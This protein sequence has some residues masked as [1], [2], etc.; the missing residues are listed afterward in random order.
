[1]MNLF[2]GDCFNLE[3]PTMG[4]K[5][6][7][8]NI[9]ERCG[10]KLQQNSFTKHA[11]ILDAEDFRVAFGDLSS[12]KDK[13][14]RLTRDD[15]LK[16]GDVF[17]VSRHNLYE[18]YGIYIGNGMVINYRG[19]YDIGSKNT[20]R[21]ER[22]KD[23]VGND[24]LFVLHFYE[25]GSVPR[26]ISTKTEFNGADRSTKYVPQ[27]FRYYSKIYSPQETI[28]RAMSK[29]GE[30]DYNLLFHNCEH[31]AMWCKTGKSICL[32]E[33]AIPNKISLVTLHNNLTPLATQ[34]VWK[35]ALQLNQNR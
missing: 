9:E 4:G 25:D 20:V 26:K 31:F 17:G 6:C 18:H 15:F 10:Y 22:L 34:P 32:Q 11:R 7:W 2:T 27:T 24:E 1:M 19:D 8:E 3:M 12:M 16:P 33:A 28:S 35:L 29:L 14:V 23:V 13:F 30:Q 5:Y 21:L